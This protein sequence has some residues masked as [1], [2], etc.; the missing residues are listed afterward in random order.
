[1]LAML[2]TILVSMVGIRS[3]VGH[4]EAKVR[5]ATRMVLVVKNF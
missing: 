2:T 3:L 4:L 5:A 1:M